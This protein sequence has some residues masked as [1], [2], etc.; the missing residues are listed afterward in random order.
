MLG[1]SINIL[2]GGTK[3]KK[4]KPSSVKKNKQKENTQTKKQ[5]NAIRKKRLR[6]HK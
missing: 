1:G 4:R 6:F 5:K 3:E 2:H